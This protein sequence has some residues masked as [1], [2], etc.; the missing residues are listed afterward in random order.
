[1]AV[2]DARRLHASGVPVEL[3][4]KTLPLVFDFDALCS[5]EEEMGGV[6][7]YAERMTDPRWRHRA[8][9]AGMVAALS[10]TGMTR[11]EVVKLLRMGD[12]SA[13]MIALSEALTEGL[14]KPEEDDE[15]DGPKARGR[16]I[17]GSRGTVTTSSRR[18]ASAGLTPSSGG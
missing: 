2:S 3:G 7:I 4:G 11:A 8:V 15:G 5:L 6:D 9:R 18:S 17:S 16:R 1:M 12:V 14:P 13:Y 10:H